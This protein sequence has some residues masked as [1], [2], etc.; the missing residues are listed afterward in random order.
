M[1][2]GRYHDA[3]YATLKAV[4]WNAS[5]ADVRGRAPYGAWKLAQILVG[6]DYMATR[7]ERDPDRKRWQRGLIVASEHFGVLEGLRG[8]AKTVLDLI[9]ELRQQGFTTDIERTWDGG[10]YTHPAPTE[11]GRSR[12]IEGRLFE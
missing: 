9:D 7:Y 10:G 3:R 5:L 8:G 2:P 6:N 12:L 1:D 4:A 11:L